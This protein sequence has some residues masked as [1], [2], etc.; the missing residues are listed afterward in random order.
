MSI[1]YKRKSTPQ[2]VGWTMEQLF[3]TAET[4]K[5]RIWLLETWFQK[6]Y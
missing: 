3:L 4:V 2:T 6:V 5:T 1:R